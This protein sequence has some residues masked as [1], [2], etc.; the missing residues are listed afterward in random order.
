MKWC[1]HCATNKLKTAFKDREDGWNLYNWCE[2]CRK[3]E[4]RDKLTPAQQT[5]IQ[6]TQLFFVQQ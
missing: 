3:G 2:E 6:K 4:G 1:N 5:F